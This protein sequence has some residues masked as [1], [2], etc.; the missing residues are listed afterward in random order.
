LKE[1]KKELETEIDAMLFTSF[2]Q[3]HILTHT[4]TQ[5]QNSLAWTSN[6][7]ADFF[8]F[9]FFIGFDFT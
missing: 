5:N 1:R 4:Q 9:G 7:L 3:T 6:L 8:H 2:I